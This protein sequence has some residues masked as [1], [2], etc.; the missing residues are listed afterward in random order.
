[1]QK[2]LKISTAS[3]NNDNHFIMPERDNEEENIEIK[4]NIWHLWK[5]FLDE[6]QDNNFLPS[7]RYWHRKSSF[8]MKTNK[9]I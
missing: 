4:N 5:K 7:L 1:V 9:L 3:N 6:A 2:K 8:I